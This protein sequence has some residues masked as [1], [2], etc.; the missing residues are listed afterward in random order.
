MFENCETSL[1][2]P[3]TKERQPRLKYLI[4]EASFSSLL[5]INN[6]PITKNSMT[7]VGES[8]QCLNHNYFSTIGP[9][10]TW[11]YVIRLY[12]SARFTVHI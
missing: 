4:R 10:Q 3:R 9:K 7:F 5:E 12:R 8:F 6:C 11:K 2:G 1:Y